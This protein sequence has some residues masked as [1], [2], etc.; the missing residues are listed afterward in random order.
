NFYGNA[1][2]ERGSNNLKIEESEITLSRL[3]KTEKY[4]FC[5]FSSREGV[6]D[7]RETK[8]IVKGQNEKA[9]SINASNNSTKTAC[10]DGI[11]PDSNGNIKIVVTIGDNNDNDWGFYYLTALK[12]SGG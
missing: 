12:I 9:T 10:V 6:S 3:D 4:N 8:F 1:R 5:F 2:K 7:N 11:V